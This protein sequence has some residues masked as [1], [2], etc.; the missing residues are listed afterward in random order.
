M[1][2]KVLMLG[3]GVVG[4]SFLTQNRDILGDWASSYGLKSPQSLSLGAP[5]TEIVQIR[6]MMQSLTTQVEHLANTQRHS[7]AVIVSNNQPTTVLGVPLWKVVGLAGVTGAIYMKVYGYEMRDLVYVSKKHFD[8]ATAALKQ[9]YEQL[10]QAVELVKVDLLQRIGLVETKVTDARDSINAKIDL[11]VGKIDRNITDLSAGLEQVDQKMDSTALR[12]DGIAIDVT[13][14]KNAIGNIS[15]ELDTRFAPVYKE[16]GLFKEETSRSHEALSS[17]INNIHSKV[18]DLARTTQNLFFG[19][20]KQSKGIG[21][22][23]DFVYQSQ[24]NPT[25][26]PSLI[27]ELQEYARSTSNQ[28]LTR[29]QSASRLKKKS[30][31]GLAGM[32]ATAALPITAN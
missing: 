30:M 25:T 21:L 12:I 13:D 17:E 1:A 8:S 27:E 26:T 29:T 19:L 11:E 16:V 3:S 10:E 31:E 4:G 28:G 24:S 14:V 9:Q 23:C 7:H 32:K 18:D 6:G 22:L 20:E 5:S 2:S 15:S